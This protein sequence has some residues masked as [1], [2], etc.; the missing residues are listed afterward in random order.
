MLFNAHAPANLWV[1][2]FS[3]AIYIINMLPTPILSNK[4]PFEV[5][6]H[7]VPNY[8]VFRIFGCRVFPYLL[9]YSPYKLAPRSTPCIFLGYCTQYKGYKCLDP[10]SQCIYTTGMLNSMKVFFPIP[11]SH[12]YQILPLW[13]SQPLMIKV[14][15]L[16]QQSLTSITT[17]H[18]LLYLLQHRLHVNCARPFLCR[19]LNISRLPLLLH[20][21]FHQ[22]S[23]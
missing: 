21:S 5:L 18:L 6:F 22:S 7:T 20:S 8:E 14:L 23:P 17:H 12:L 1:H 16:C 4:S 3:S 2:A 15:H 10:T 11:V 13:L 9:D 19:C